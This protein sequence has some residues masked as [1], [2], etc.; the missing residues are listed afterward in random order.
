MPS[1]QNKQTDSLM[2]LVDA[3]YKLHGFGLKDAKY[4]Y[5]RTK[6]ILESGLPSGRLF[7]S[8]RSAF[9]SAYERCGFD[10]PRQLTH[11]LRHTFASHFMMAGGDILTLQR[12]LG[13]SS[14]QVT[15]RYAHLSPSHLQAVLTL[16]PLSQLFLL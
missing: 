1:E 16:S 14:I 15:M 9:R 5:S 4:R 12:I 10:T 2:D 11:I 6:A 7:M 13:H 3:W 8:C